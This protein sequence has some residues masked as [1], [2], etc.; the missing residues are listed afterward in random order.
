MTLNSDGQRR[1]VDGCSVHRYVDA[2]G[3]PLE[4]N[5]VLVRHG[6]LERRRRIPGRIGDL[7]A[8]KRLVPV[9]TPF[10]NVAVNVM[11]PPGIRGQL[12]VRVRR[13]SRVARPPQESVGS[14]TGLGLVELT[15]V[16]I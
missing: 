6:Q 12:R 1:P 2:G 16:E 8:G 15:L 5:R 14:R 7:E 10:G 3:E 9:D 4:K 11:E 13:L